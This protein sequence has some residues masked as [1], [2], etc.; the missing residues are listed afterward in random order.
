VEIEMT[1]KSKDHELAEIIA[2]MLP[3]SAAADAIREFEQHVKDGKNPA[4]LLQD[5][6]WVVVRDIQREWS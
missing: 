1:D 3:H 5:G 4:I 6:A 2:G